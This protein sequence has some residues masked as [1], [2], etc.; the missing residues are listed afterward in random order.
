MKTIPIEI[1]NGMLSAATVS[2]LLLATLGD[3]TQTGL[4]LFMSC[5]S[6]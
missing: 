6:R 2:V 3:A 5:H 1:G 4:F